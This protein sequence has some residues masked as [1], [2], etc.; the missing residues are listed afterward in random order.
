LRKIN[1]T[2]DISQKD[3]KHI[4][5]IIIIIII[6]NAGVRLGGGWLPRLQHRKQEFNFAGAK[7]HFAVKPAKELNS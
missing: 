7:M 4:I 1:I 5:I 6:N 2:L 3:E